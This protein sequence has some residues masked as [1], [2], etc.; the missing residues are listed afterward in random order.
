MVKD[1][2]YTTLE[3]KRV[4]T[5]SEQVQ[6]KLN[7]EICEGDVTR[8][9]HSGETV[10]VNSPSSNI[11]NHKETYKFYLKIHKE[12]PYD[13]DDKIKKYKP[14]KNVGKDDEWNEEKEQ[15][16]NSPEWYNK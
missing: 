11:I 6:A 8:T 14:K 9:N 7:Q 5:G 3:E 12:T 15:W 16:K 13:V 4:I 1:K 10:R 2:Q